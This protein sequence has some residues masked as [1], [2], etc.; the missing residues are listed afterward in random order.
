MVKFLIHRPI[1][2][3]MAFLAFLFIGIAT[4]V[5]IPVSLM[6]DIDIPVI[7][8]RVP[9][10]EMPA[11]QLENSVVKQIRS[12][13]KEVNH[14]EEMKSETRD[15]TAWI[16]L[17]F[18]HGT[19][20][21][22][23]SIEV[24]EKVDKAMNYLPR[25]MSRPEV[26]RASASDIPVFYLMVN[27][28]QERITGN[29]EEFLQLSN[30]T[31]QVIRK[32]L[33]QLPEVALVDISGLQYPEIKITPH[34]A[35]LQNGTFTISQLEQELNNNN[36]DL[37]NLLIRDGQYQYN[38]RFNTRLRDVSEIAEIP[39]NLNGKV[40][41]LSEIADVSLQ[42]QKPQGNIKI[43]SESA[44]SLAVIKQS[45][46]KMAD[47]KDELDELVGYF[48]D[49]YPELEFNITRDQSKL[50][51]YSINNLGQSL[52]IGG[53]LAFLIL[54]VFLRERKAP[55]LIGISIPV[56]LLLSLFFFYLFKL[57]INI[58]SLSG[59]ILGVGMMIDNSIIV[60]DN[61]TQYRDRHFTLS[62][63]CEVGTNEVIRPL[64]SSVLTTCAVFIPLI[65]MKGMAGALFFDQAI[66]VTIGLGISLLVS[67]TLLP[68]LYRLFYSK[69]KQ[70][71]QKRQKDP[72]YYRWYE[73]GLKFVL[74][75]Q[76]ATI[77]FVLL[78]L[79]GAAVLARMLTTSRFPEV[80]QDE[81]VLKIDWNEPLTLEENNKRVNEL[82]ASLSTEPVYVIEEA[83]KQQYLLNSGED[84]GT[85]E[86]KL[87]I[88]AESPAH[89]S[90]M[91]KTLSTYFANHFPAADYNFTEADN[92]FNL[93]FGKSEA[94]LIARFSHFNPGNK[95]YLDEL[96]A[97]LADL[98]K[99]YHNS[100]QSKLITRQLILLETD[101]EKLMFYEVD[102]DELYRE[103][104]S[105]FNVNTVFTINNN[106]MFVPVSI[107]NSY[108]SVYQI[109][110]NI[111]VRNQNN[112][113][114]PLSGLVKVNSGSGLKSIV[115]GKENE[116]FPVEFEINPGDFKTV[117]A[118]IKTIAAN[119]SSFDLSFGGSILSNRAM[120][121]EL[122]MIIGVS[123]LLLYFI[124][125]AQ[126]ES[127]V[128]PVIV[129]LE[130]PIDLFGAFLALKLFGAGINIMSAIGIIVM[131][132][133]IINDSI[134]KID[135]MNK[136][137]DSGYSLIRSVME[138]G[139]RRL[140]PIIMTS[141]TTIL[142]M[143]PFLFQKGMGAEL[144]QPLALAIIGGMVLG[145]LVSLYFIPIMYYLLK[146]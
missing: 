53:L 84:A 22:L 77:V 145:T 90:K 62:R 5:Q 43:N 102:N 74:R 144:Q 108:Q 146:K 35:Y 137:H 70:E 40:V 58:I 48:K 67:I 27:K 64:I 30:F 4:T 6:P 134:L 111:Q 79:A 9:S 130:V 88:K 116:Y 117:S 87:I 56:S 85:T 49:D 136:L 60:I 99:N 7:S 83:G 24:N 13:L 47:L 59:L 73:R 98:D 28:K 18:K 140:K 25:D 138:A 143:L 1:A 45:D 141:L 42:P 65:F 55:W 19:S 110:Q 15:G 103:V 91:I 75:N 92:L 51:E 17:R 120:L 96:S 52:L 78:L 115:A 80:S 114:I 123:L 21:D 46:A 12:V 139:H 142:A 121:T 126:F 113:E 93:A 61:I 71:K 44:I 105:A 100:L 135:T 3:T 14:I 106:N 38:I 122:L 94:P 2:V 124:L 128:L 129:L 69:A 89:L 86:N 29:K 57:S 16:E 31:S 104:K 20:I 26:I 81:I 23:A 101:P 11:R 10:N 32:R 131:A 107:G 133:I 33:E 66:A 68:T 72:G 112:E 63:A 50:L 118:D 127:F 37:G 76:G 119:H 95:N 8:I 36:I 109:I 41:S 34:T 82:M 54:F 39:V 97:L 132:G 125:A